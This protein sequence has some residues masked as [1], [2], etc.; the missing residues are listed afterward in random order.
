MTIDMMIKNNGEV[1]HNGKTYVLT[2]PAYINGPIDAPY[3]IASAICPEDG[4]DEDG[5]YDVYDITWYPTQE[6]L[7]SERD[8]EGWACDWDNPEDVRKT[9][10]GYNLADDSIEYK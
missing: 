9:E 3:Y 8:D 10:L 1:N 2:Q 5:L 6:W 7:D 4:V